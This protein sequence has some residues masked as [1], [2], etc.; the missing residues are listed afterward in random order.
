M[1]EIH[2]DDCLTMLRGIRSKSV[3]LVI[4]DPPYDVDNHGGGISKLGHRVAHKQIETISNSFDFIILDELCRVMKKINIYLFCSKNQLVPLINYFTDKKCNWNLL[5]WHK[6]N[7][8]PTCNNKYLPDTE[9]VLFFREK[10]VKIQGTYDTKKT[11]FI[12]PINVKD[13]ELYQHPTCKPV[14][15]LKNFIVN[16]SNEN[17]VVLDPFMGSGSTGVACINTHRNFIGIEINA[18]FY[19]TAKNET[20]LTKKVIFKLTA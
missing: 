20:Y 5:T 15:I 14:D 11:Y 1:I 13:K 9:Y 19:E 12:T 8:I 2:N 7:P 10:G 3:D 17:D 6:T 16:S 18:K 4:T